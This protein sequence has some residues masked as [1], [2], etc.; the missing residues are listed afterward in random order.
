MPHENKSELLNCR[1]VLRKVW[2]HCWQVACFAQHLCREM[3]LYRIAGE[4]AFLAGL[5]HEW[6][7]LILV[8]NFSDQFRAAC[9]AARVT[10]SAL[11]LRLMESF[12]A[13]TVA[14]CAFYDYVVAA[15]NSAGESPASISTGGNP[16]SVPSV[17]R[18]L[19][20]KPNRQQNLYDG[21]SGGQ[22][23]YRYLWSQIPPPEIG[24]TPP[25]AGTPTP[26]R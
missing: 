13:T 22:P 2:N 23:V 9:Q 12:R 25:I 18:N 21:K 1:V 6:G 26:Q 24:A 3:R 20:A 14:N 11:A 8:D 15:V 19:A 17:P 7:Q 4:E 10:K 16:Q 5:L